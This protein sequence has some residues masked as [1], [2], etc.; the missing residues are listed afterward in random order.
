MVLTIYRRIDG[1]LRSQSEN[2]SHDR[3][4]MDLY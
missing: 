3:K 2:N 4:L 1:E